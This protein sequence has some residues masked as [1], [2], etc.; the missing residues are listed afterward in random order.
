MATFEFGCCHIYDVKRNEENNLQL[1][2]EMHLHM[3]LIGI[4]EFLLTKNRKFLH[5]S[6][7]T[8]VNKSTQDLNKQYVR[9]VIWLPVYVRQ[10]IYTKISISQHKIVLGADQRRKA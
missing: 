10:Q 2:E 6:I 9:N 7:P 8:K 5:I 1:E 3:I 4:Q